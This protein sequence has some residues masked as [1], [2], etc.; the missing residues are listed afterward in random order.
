VGCVPRTGPAISVCHQLSTTIP[1]P[2]LT[3]TA[4]AQRWAS[5]LRGSPAQASRRSLERSKRLGAS[6]PWLIHMRRAV[7]AVNMTFTPKR[8]AS[9]QVTSGPG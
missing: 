1:S 5:G 8:S 2:W 4:W 6:L 3:S 9:S 7:G